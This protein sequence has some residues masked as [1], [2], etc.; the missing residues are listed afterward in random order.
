MKIKQSLKEVHTY[1]KLTYAE[2]CIDEMPV[3]EFTFECVDKSPKVPTTINMRKYC[4]VSLTRPAIDG[5]PYEYEQL[6]DINI[7]D[8]VSIVFKAENPED[9]V[10]EHRPIRFYKP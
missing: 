10:E 1:Y 2:L 7:G 4:K 8:I 5:C 3:W 6:Y 9:W